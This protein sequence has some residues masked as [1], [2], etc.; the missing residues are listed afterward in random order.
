[1][2][3]RGKYMH[4]VEQPIPTGRK[5]AIYEISENAGNAILGHIKWYAP[6]R[7]FCWF[8]ACETVFDVGCLSQ[9]IFWIRGLN[10]QHEEKRR[11]DAPTGAES[12]VPE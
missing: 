2:L 5:T 7:G 4:M 8:P 1:M 11:D 9:I 10:T 3:M 6:W 12:E